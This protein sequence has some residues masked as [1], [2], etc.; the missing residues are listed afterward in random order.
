[1]TRRFRGIP[2]ETNPSGRH[3][4]PHEREGRRQAAASFACSR[5]M[6]RSRLRAAE[7]AGDGR[8]DGKTAPTAHSSREAASN[9]QRAQTKRGR[10]AVSSAPAPVLGRLAADAPLD[11]RA[12]RRPPTRVLQTAPTPGI[13][14]VAP[15]DSSRWTVDA[16]VSAPGSRP[17]R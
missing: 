15:F 8:E 3:G 16:S 12:A 13:L 10:A 7:E 2:A 14:A 1:M 17:R 6:R 11:E 5:S 9:Q 4:Q